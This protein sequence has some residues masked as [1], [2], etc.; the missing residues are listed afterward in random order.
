MSNGCFSEKRYERLMYF[1]I[2]VGSFSSM[3]GRKKT[4]FIE[5]MKMDIV[6]YHIL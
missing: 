6:T 1:I 4:R 2:S 5:R 3:Q